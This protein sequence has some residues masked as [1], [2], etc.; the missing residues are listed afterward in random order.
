VTFKPRVTRP[1]LPLEDVIAALASSD[2]NPKELAPEELDT[3]RRQLTAVTKMVGAKMAETSTKEHSYDNDVV[4][5]YIDKVL[6]DGFN[7][8]ATE[9][10]TEPE[11]IEAQRLKRWAGLIAERVELS[12]FGSREFKIYSLRLLRSNIAKVKTLHDL[13]RAVVLMIEPLRLY[14]QHR[15]LLDQLDADSIETMKYISSLLVDIEQKDKVLADRKRVIDEILAVYSEDDGDIALLR[16]IE[17]AKTQH[18]LSDTEAA[19]WFG[20]TRRRLQSL[21]EKLIS[22]AP[23]EESLLMLEQDSNGGDLQGTAVALCS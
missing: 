5:A 21:R 23:Q 6:E 11:L 7:L 18:R 19:G 17:S 15:A 12:P 20:C 2:I 16:N 4:T 3:Y 22:S 9:L 1:E 14:R 10:S 8:V 13:R